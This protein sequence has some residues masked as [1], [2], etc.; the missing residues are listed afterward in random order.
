VAAS[1]DP[2][3]AIHGLRSL[4]RTMKAAEL[5]LADLKAAHAK[6][7]ALVLADAAANAPVRTGRLAATVRASATPSYAVVRAGRAAVPYAAPIHWGWRARGIQ[8]QPFLQD[9]IESNRDEV[10]GIMLH[11]L[12]E[13]IDT[14]EGTPGP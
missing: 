14:I 4:V 9:A 6:I 7:A 12:T 2:A 13:I 1:R 10:V 5:D 3:V 8:Q 11:K